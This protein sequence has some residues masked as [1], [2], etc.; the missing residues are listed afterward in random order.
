MIVEAALANRHRARF[1]VRPELGNVHPRIEPARVVRVHT[2][3]IPQEAA[4]AGGERPASAS[5]AEDIPG[6][7]AGA[8]ADDRV[9]PAL[10]RALYYVVAV[11]VE[12]LV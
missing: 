6:A 1:S 7:A 3:C 10:S 12:R 11:A 5:G 9:G 2:G 8:D 4:V